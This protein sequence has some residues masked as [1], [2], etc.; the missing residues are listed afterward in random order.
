MNQPSP[1][2]RQR[3]AL[4]RWTLPISFALLAVLYQLG[5]ARWVH[6][7]YGHEIHYWVE[8]AFYGTAGPL[9]TL[10]ALTHIGRWLE[11]K[12]QAEH[13]ARASE[14]R[15][16]SITAASADAILSLDAHGH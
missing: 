4:L 14:Q 12:A 15:L 11:A 9:L 8:I 13:Q 3:I 10:W 7:R 2:F 5:P 6:D 1:A 16:A